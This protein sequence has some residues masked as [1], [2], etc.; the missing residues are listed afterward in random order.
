MC[1][2]LNS[3]ASKDI[4]TASHAYRMSFCYIWSVQSE[5]QA[6]CVDWSSERRFINILGLLR[7]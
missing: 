2:E 5:L 7:L 4:T 6:A 3:L 1:I